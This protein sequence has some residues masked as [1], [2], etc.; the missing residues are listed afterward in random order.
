[1]QTLTFSPQDVAGV[2]GG[3]GMCGVRG[4]TANSS[5]HARRASRWSCATSSSKTSAISRCAE[6][7]DGSGS[8]AVNSPLPPLFA[9]LYQF[10]IKDNQGGEDTTALRYLEVIGTPRDA[11]DMKQFQ[12]VAGKA[13]EADH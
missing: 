12:R 4:G 9:L 7:G 1:M 2:S 11:T 5:T 8:A 6:G 3:G 10:F 13:G